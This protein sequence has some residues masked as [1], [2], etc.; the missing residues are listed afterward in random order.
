MSIALT[1]AITTTEANR[2]ELVN[3]FRAILPDTRA[4]E[5][6]QSVQLAADAEDPTKLI[7]IEFWESAERYDAYRAWRA[8]SGTSVLASD[9]V[10]GHQTLTSGEVIA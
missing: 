9:L 7:L 8:E 10:V 3:S 5:G 4:F 2:E 1:I 6:C